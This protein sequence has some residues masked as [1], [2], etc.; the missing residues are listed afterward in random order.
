MFYKQ[1]LIVLSG[2]AGCSAMEKTQESKKNEKL[3]IVTQDQEHLEVPAFCIPLCEHF[4]NMTEDLACQ[5][6]EK[7]EVSLP[8]TADDMKKFISILAM[9][10]GHKEAEDLL[11]ER[12]RILALINFLNCPSVF[13]DILLELSKAID[14]MKYSAGY[15]LWER[16]E[17][18]FE[19]F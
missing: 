11:V 14:L 18:I 6:Q 2:F 13:K 10:H 19:S 12:A 5:S 8:W 4:K 9:K 17:K 1:C 15:V 3:V 16:L 7:H